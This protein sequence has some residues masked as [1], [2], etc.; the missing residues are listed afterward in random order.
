MPFRLLYGI[1]DVLS[2]LLGR[3]IRYRY[4]VVYQN[5]RL[6]FPEKPESEIHQIICRFYRHLCDILLESVKGLTLSEEEL[7][8]RYRFENTELADEFHRKGQSTILTGAHYCNWEWMVIS[9]N[10]WFEA[11][12]VGIYKPISNPYIENYLNRLRSKFGL[13]LAHPKESRAVLSTPKDDAQ[14]FIL[15]ADQYP[16]NSQ[17]SLKIPFFHIPTTWLHGIDSVAR[18]NNYPVFYYDIQ[19]VKRGYYESKIVP[20]CL[21]PQQTAI[22][23]IATQYVQILENILQRE[24]AF[25]LWSHKRWKNLG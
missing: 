15:L 22:G 17:S 3:V 4:K 8:K 24:P 25:W 13:Q 23:E 19:R 12:L 16:S 2:F 14:M 9:V 21:E 1:S 11:Q 7:R 18:A 20:V 5:L 6:V 10:V